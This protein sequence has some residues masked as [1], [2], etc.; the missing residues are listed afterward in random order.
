MI[1][2]FSLGDATRSLSGL[3]LKNNLKSHY[4]SLP[5]ETINFIKSECLHALSD[6]SNLI[7]ATVG[8]L[9][10]TIQAKGKIENWPELIPSLCHLLDS[11]DYHAVEGA[12]GALQKICEDSADVLEADETN[13]PLNVL[14]PK[15]LQFFQHS[16]ARIRSHAIACVNQFIVCK[17]QA[18]QDNIEL[19]VQVCLQLCKVKLLISNLIRITLFVVPV[20]LGRR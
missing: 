20:P 9:I 4:D 16:S 5:V 2:R 13:R 14:I 11:N 8:I 6:P 18:L 7:R 17:S 15:F 19:F 10:T 3:I 12:F 1:F